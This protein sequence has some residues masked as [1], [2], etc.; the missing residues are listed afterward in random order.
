MR[1]I[2][3]WCAFLIVVASASACGGG[4]TE[5]HG[6]GVQGGPTIPTGATDVVVRVDTRGGFTSVEYQLGIV[7]QLT[8]YGDGRVVVEGPTAAIY[9]GPALPNLRTGTLPRRTVTDLVEQARA[10]GLFQPRDLGRPGVTDLPTT[11][12]TFFPGPCPAE[13]KCGPPTQRAY[14]LDFNDDG[15]SARLSSAQ[16]DARAAL[17]RFVRDTSE[18]ANRVAKEP[19][20]ASDVAVYVSRATN[21]S[22]DVVQPGRARVTWPLDDLAAFAVTETAAGQFPCHIVNGANATAVLAAADRATSIT[23]W[24]SAGTDYSIVWRPLLP[25]EHECPPLAS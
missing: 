17:R 11:T 25:D 9:P 22:D 6:R 10:A 5:N 24:S 23:R 20:H 3:T 4:S 15:A 2:R 1:T 18:A 8:V 19:F 16:R 21:E 7:P 13:G 12:V 14:A